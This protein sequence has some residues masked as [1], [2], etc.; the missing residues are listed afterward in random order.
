MA[1]ESLLVHETTLDAAGAV[2]ILRGEEVRALSVHRLLGKLQP[3]R[4]RGLDLVF[5]PHWYCSFRVV[6]EGG[7]IRPGTARPEHV[8]PAVWTMVDALTGQVLRLPGEPPLVT[9]DLATLAPAV[10]VQ[11][12][13]E[14]EQAVASALENLRWDLRIRG[15]QRVTPRELEPV[16]SRLAYVPFWVGYYAGANG[17]VR[18][19]SVHGIE[20]S[21][22]KDALTQELIR[23]LGRIA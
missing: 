22:Q 15:R 14:R 23:A 11:P 9:R 12:N 18:A 16:E 3:D 20:R 7:S 19:R 1:T 2:G 4:M 6:L 21:I 5:V 8:A 10:A 17:Q 13:I